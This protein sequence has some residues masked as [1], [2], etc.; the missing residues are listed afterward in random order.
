MGGVLHKTCWVSCKS[1]IKCRYTVA[2]CW[3]FYVS[4]TIMHGSTNINTCEKS[5][6]FSEFLLGRC[7]QK[8]SCPYCQGSHR[9][10]HEK[11]N[12]LLISVLHD[13][14]KTTSYFGCPIREKSLVSIW[15]RGWLDQSHGEQKLKHLC[16]AQ[17]FL[18]SEH[19]PSQTKKSLHRIETEDSLPCSQQPA[20]CSYSETDITFHDFPSVLRSFLILFYHLSLNLPGI[21]FPPDPTTKTVHATLFSSHVT[22]PHPSYSPWLY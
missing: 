20:G 19:F 14:E 8:Q 17:N 6:Y 11:N 12:A 9:A 5:N 16:G 10:L 22:K 13:S 4:Y 18:H 3:T 7:S 21:I 2:S 1:E 15:C